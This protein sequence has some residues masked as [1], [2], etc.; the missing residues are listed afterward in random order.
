MLHNINTIQN[1]FD[2]LLLVSTI[3]IY[4]RIKFRISTI[5]DHTT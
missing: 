3:L 4:N 2:Y 5:L 1:F